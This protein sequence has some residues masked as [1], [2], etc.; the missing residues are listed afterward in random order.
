MQDLGARVVLSRTRVSRLVTE[1]EARAWSSAVA[2]PSRR[3]GDA[4]DDHP[5]PAAP[6][7]AEPLRST[8]PAS[9]SHFNRHLTAAQRRTIAEVLQRVLDAHEPL[10][11]VRR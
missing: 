4:G 3:S 5:P 10:L 9:T 2:G 7:S 11:D 6:P 1:L 8:S